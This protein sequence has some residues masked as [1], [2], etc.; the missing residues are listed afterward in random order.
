MKPFVEFPKMA[1]LSRD[2]II[3]EKID[4]TNASIDIVFID[5]DNHAYDEYGEVDKS[6]I[7]TID[8]YNIRAGSRT[9]WVTPKDDNHGW[10]KW[11]VDHAKE[12]VELGEGTHFGE[13]WGSG[14]QRGYGLTKGEKRFSLFNTYRWRDGGKDVRPACCSVVPILYEGP[15]RDY[16]IQ[17]ALEELEIRGSKAAPGFTNPEGICVFHTAANMSFKKTIIKDESPKSLVK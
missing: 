12:L 9:K 6:I 7:A 13:W 5:A 2:I 11:V 14:I 1:R 15:F 8:E 10:A 16:K 3:T 4:G 17:E